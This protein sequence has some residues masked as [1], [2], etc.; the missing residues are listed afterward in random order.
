M[1]EGNK[2]FDVC[3]ISITEIS[4]DARTLNMARTLVKN[5][6]SVCIIA[7]GNQNDSEKLSNENIILFPV[8]NKN[9]ARALN[10]ITN[11]NKEAKYY[12]D[13]ASAKN[14]I[15][16]DL[17][18]LRIAVKLKKIIGGKL[19]Y[20]SRE[21][22]SA[23]GPLSGKPIKQH[24]ITTFERHHIK[25]VNKFI[26]TGSLDEEYLR[27]HFKKEK[28]FSIIMNLPP[29]RDRIQSNL[30]RE[31]YSFTADK[32]ILIYQG[33]LL[34]GRGIIPVIKTLKYFEEAVFCI[35]GQGP[36]REEIINE[37]IKC[38]VNERVILCGSVPYD[39]LHDWTSSADIGVSFIE[40]ISF[41]YQLAL[42]NKLFEYCMARIPSL[43]SDLPA[44]KK[45]MDE[46]QIGIA[47][48]P[49]SSSEQIAEALKILCDGANKEIYSKN[50][51]SACHT[52]NFEAQKDKI[53]SLVSG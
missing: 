52:L 20:D 50:C 34:R 13:I 4:N 53:L 27:K 16:E 43:V 18:S 25:H 7:Y 5:G 37:S 46:Y 30:L 31:K 24:L 22:Y 36:L 51:E 21:I 15:A 12:F 17:Y 45:I 41:S 3:F 29:Y 11:F 2:I 9:F 39:E 23:L 49:D 6:Y 44:M 48:S 38:K 28:P 40:P 33:E 1:L 14:Y 47:I 8:E 42:P 10:R 32:K 35:L 26:V 19:L